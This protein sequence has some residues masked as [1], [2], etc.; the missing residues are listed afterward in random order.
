MTQCR[1]VSWISS[2]PNALARATSTTAL[3][4]APIRLSLFV[5]NGPTRD[6]SAAPIAFDTALPPL[7][8]VSSYLDFQNHLPGPVFLIL[9]LILALHGRERLRDIV[10][11]IT[12]D[13]VE[14]KIGRIRFR[15]WLA[16]PPT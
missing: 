3:R 2:V 14:V 12:L 16:V 13:T 6:Q 15:A 9:L 11:I 8:P 10:H 4:Y 1:T 7:S 5:A